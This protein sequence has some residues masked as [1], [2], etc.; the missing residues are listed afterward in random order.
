MRAVGVVLLGPA[1]PV[2]LCAVDWCGLRNDAHLVWRRALARAAHTTV[3]R[4]AVQ[5]VHQH[6]APFVCPEAERIVTAQGDLPHTFFVD[7]L[8]TCI[9]RAA[10]S[11]AEAMTRLRPLTHIA[12]GQGKVEK[13][14]SNRRFVGENG[15]IVDWRGSSSKNPVH[16]ELPEGLIDPWLKTVAFYDGDTKAINEFMEN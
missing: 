15:M 1:A 11:V 10:N 13:V 4:V 14:A 16:W 2:V 5:C 8:E 7:F 12:T 9:E 6:N 3:E